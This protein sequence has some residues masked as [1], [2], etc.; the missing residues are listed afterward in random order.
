MHSRALSFAALRT[1]NRAR[2]PQFKNK[3]GGAAHSKPDGSDWTPAQWFQALLG[4]VGEF[5]RVR[6]Q[7]E[8]GAI[9]YET[10][11]KEARKELADVQCY[12]DLLSMR[13]LDET[14]SAAGG[15][16]FAQ[17][18]MELVANL[19]EYANWRKKLER[20]DIDAQKFEQVALPHLAAS[21]EHLAELCSPGERERAVVTRAHP[22]GVDLGRATEDK[23]NEVSERVGTKV[24]LLD[25]QAAVA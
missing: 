11:C 7:Y 1:A 21:T 8:A 15:P 2:V 4:E 10:Y 18:L 14:R 5:A 20:G 16:D 17:V 6:Q 23:F 12:L 25:G 3:L 24:F 22:L 9:D 13:A 19:G